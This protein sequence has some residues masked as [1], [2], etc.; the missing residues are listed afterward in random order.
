MNRLKIEFESN[1]IKR[2]AIQCNAMH[3]TTITFEEVLIMNNVFILDSYPKVFDG[4]KSFSLL[5]LT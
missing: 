5:V 1:Q 3:S 2:E 4:F